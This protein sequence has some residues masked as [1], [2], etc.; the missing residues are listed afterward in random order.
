MQLW[1]LGRAAEPEVLR[2]EGHPYVSSSASTL[3]RKGYPDIAPQ[4][5]TR[6]GIKKY[7]EYYAQAARN[8]VFGAGFDGVE[9][10]GAKWVA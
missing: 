6:S 9:I 3:Q 10:H 7:V 5:L 8:A 4:E 1:A 2:R